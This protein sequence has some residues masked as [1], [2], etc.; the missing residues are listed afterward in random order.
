MP[1]WGFSQSSRSV[2][3]PLRASAERSVSMDELCLLHAAFGG[4]R[5]EFENAAQL[6]EAPSGGTISALSVQL[7]AIRMLDPTLRQAR[8]ILD[9]GFGSGVMVAMLLLRASEQAEIWGVDLEDKIP[10][11]RRNLLGESPKCQRSR[12]KELGLLPISEERFHLI[13]GDAFEL[14]SSNREDMFDIIY[15]GC[16]LDPETPQLEMLLKGLSRNGAAVFNYGS[17]RQ[18]GMWYISAEGD[19]NI[20]CQLLMTVNFMMCVSSAA[21]KDD[22]VRPGPF[23]Q[24]AF[25]S[26][27]QKM[28]SQLNG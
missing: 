15:V 27:V 14:L 10:I 26:Y 8:R 6:Q 24:G 7:P 5:L 3:H 28:W 17:P 25:C 1:S 22:V 2:V 20:N 12:C 16:S 4:D 9:V 13:G 11:A 21:P 19:G 18:Q 23:N